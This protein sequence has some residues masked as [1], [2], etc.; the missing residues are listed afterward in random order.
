MHIRTVV[1]DDEPPA[2]DLIAG[3]LA[4]EPDVDLVGQCANGREAVAAIKD[5]APDLVFMD[6]QMPGLDGFGALA[7]VPIER[8]PLIVFV[9]AYDQYA[10]RAFEVHA[11]DYLLK[12]FEYDRV[13][14]AVARARSQLQHR[15]SPPDQSRVLDLLQELNNRFSAW[16]RIAVRD[17]KGVT[18][19]KP[20]DIHWIEAEGNY[21]RLHVPPKSHLLR[22]TLSAVEA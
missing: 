14:E 21:V 4:R 11:I 1:V 3:L 15:R 5:L 7:A 2:R 8:W 17:S 13:H 22:E 18:F 20:E 16:D 6:I 9:T 10:V 19:I 12:P